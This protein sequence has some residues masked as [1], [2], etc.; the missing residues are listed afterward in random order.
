MPGNSNSGGFNENSGCPSRLVAEQRTIG[1]GLAVARCKKRAST[2]KTGSAREKKKQ[3][4]TAEEAARKRKEDA[5]V[6]RQARI[7]KA[8]VERVEAEAALERLQAATAPK[9]PRAG[10]DGPDKSVDGDDDEEDYFSDDEDD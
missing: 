8:M 1:G 10:G 6:D 7:A 3:K 9:L 5:E 4:D 2:L